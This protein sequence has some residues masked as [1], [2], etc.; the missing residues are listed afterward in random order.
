[1]MKHAENKSIDIRPYK[2]SDLSK[3]E[4]LDMFSVLQIKH[5]KGVKTEN[6]LCAFEN[7]NMIGAGILILFQDNRAEFY[8]YADNNVTVK[9][10]LADCLIGRFF[11][12]QKENHQSMVLRACH[13]SDELEEIQFLLS[14]GFKT[15]NTIMWLKYDLSGEIAHYAIP[16][17]VEIKPYEFN[18]ESMTEYLKA[19]E[20][21][22]LLPQKDSAD[23]WFRTGAPGFSCFAAFHNDKVIGSATILDI[24]QACGA[25]EFIFVLPSYRRKNIARELI[26]TALTEL[27]K[28]GKK[29]ASLT[30]FGTNLPAVN[31]YLSM[32]YR[33]AGSMIELKCR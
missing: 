9:T 2:E 12:L 32:G 20:A 26:A 19:A 6:V 18:G 30:V 14:K 31:L 28:R 17:E 4:Q 8:T 15:D 13:F 24:S 5:H 33:V 3:L 27:K 16:D 7:E 29:E 11:E 22:E 23:S 21:A 10:M 1:M 25:T